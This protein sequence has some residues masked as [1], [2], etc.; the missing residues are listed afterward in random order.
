MLEKRYGCL[1]TCLHCRAI[2]LE[3]AQSLSTDSFIMALMRFIN[4]RGVPR[5]LFSDNGGNFVGAERE[6]GDWLVA[7]D[8]RKIAAQLAERKIEW[9]FNP[10]FASHRGGSWERM[11]RSVRRILSSLAFGKSMDEEILWTYLS[12]AER[13]VNDRPITKVRESVDEPKA[14]RPSDLTQPKGHEVLRFDLPLEVLADKRW[15]AV[16]RMTTE[17]WNRWRKEYLYT[18]QTRQKWLGLQQELAVGDLVI[19]E[20]ESTPRMAWPLGIIV[21]VHKSEDG[22]VRTVDVKTNK[23]MT[24]RDIRKVYLLEGSEK[25]GGGT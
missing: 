13:I 24:K 15:K 23:G 1:F 19:L 21:A 9:H 20:T 12:Y 22:L 3:L 10:P 8:Q 5:S 25:K 17:F 18:L 11:I 2:H 14:L 7:I 16:S 4:R 6:L